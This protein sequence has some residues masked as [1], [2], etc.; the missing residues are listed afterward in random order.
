MLNS[1]RLVAFRQRCL[2]TTADIM[3]LNQN[4]VMTMFKSKKLLS[5]T[6]AAVML[7][8]V[9]TLP[10]YA[11]FEFDEP[12]NETERLQL[13]DRLIVE[14]QWDD[15]LKQIDLALKANPKNV[16]VQFK[17]AVV[18]TRMGNRTMAKRLLNQ[19]ISSY[20][21]IIEPYNNLAAIYAS[22]GNYAKARELLT[23]AVT[24]NP[25]FAMGYENL[26]DLA[27]QGRH[28]DEQLALE[29]YKKALAITPRDKPL[30]RKTKALEDKLQESNQ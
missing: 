4:G 19:M 3:R 18:Y 1:K 6:L 26:G 15:A 10:A 5:L 28:A 11:A 16:Q 27:L 30:A 14:K 8:A 23:Q 2:D 12:R 7:A 13:V 24:L 22:E 21:E 25:N 9:G 20:P 29:F 17:R